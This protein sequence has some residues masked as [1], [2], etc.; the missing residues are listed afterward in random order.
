MHRYEVKLGSSHYSFSDLKDV[1]AKASPLR[2]G[3][4]LANLAASSA[5]ERVAAQTVLADVPLS[6]FLEEQLIDYD[7][8]EVTRLILDEHDA[9]A[10]RPINGLTVGQFREYLLCYETTTEIL[11]ALA[12]GLTPEMVAAVSKLCRNQDL[13]LIAS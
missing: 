13:M 4:C 10:F 5:K 11:T 12:P 8:D 2:S 1:M 6:R 7:K 9:E 3:D